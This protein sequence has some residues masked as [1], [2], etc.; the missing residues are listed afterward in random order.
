MEVIGN[1]AGGIAH[2]FNNIL[3][4]IIGYAE[5]LMDDLE[6]EEVPWSNANE[7]RKAALR[8]KEVVQRILT[9]GRKQRADL[10]PMKIG[11]IVSESVLLMRSTVPATI[12]IVTDIQDDPAVMAS[13]D[14]V[15]QIVMNLC[16]NAYQSM[17]TRG[18]TITVTLT[19]ASPETTLSGEKESLTWLRLSVADTGEGMEPWV[20]QK[21]FDPYFTTRKVGEGTGMG[22]AV[23]DG[24]VKEH[25][26]WVDV[27]STLGKGSRFD[28]W[29]PLIETE[30]ISKTESA[31]PLQS[32]RGGR[33]LL[34]D[35]DEKIVEMMRRMLT[36]AGYEVIAYKDGKSALAAMTE[37]P[38]RFQCLVTDMTM[39]EMTG[40]ELADRVLAI[41]PDIP[42]ILCTGYSEIIDRDQAISLGIR[43]FLIKPI[44]RQVLISTLEKV[45]Q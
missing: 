36:R 30:K 5:M 29:F 40:I 14:Q 3:F 1:L 2:D 17:R 25:G 31:P 32:R 33:I 15:R 9:F 37:A 34:V 27:K 13:A 28:V 4:P 41:C 23:I 22:L 43:E 35:D 44:E 11:A 21:I 45:I 7:I 20:R 42:V 19:V 38:E 18:G 26:G 12:E 6:G 8:A 39:P 16:T 24:I 10:K